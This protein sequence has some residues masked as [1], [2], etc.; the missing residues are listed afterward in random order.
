MILG[1]MP[2]TASLRA[3]RYYA[4]PQN[5][6][7]PMMGRILAFNSCLAPS[8]R[9]AVLQAHHIGL[10]DVIGRCRRRG[11]LDAAIEVGSIETNPIAPLLASFAQLE[12]ILCNGAVAYRVWKQKV[13][14]TLTA[15]Y[16]VLQLPST[17]AANA[18]WS[19][20]ALVREWRCALDSPERRQL[21]S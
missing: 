8:M 14:P 15:N 13:A 4:H 6:F 19:M 18:S 12:R 5:R 3:G 16:S 11:S 1:S 20:D 9:V 2:S 10:W 17:S 7:W 21:Q